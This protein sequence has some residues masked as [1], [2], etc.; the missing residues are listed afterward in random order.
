MTIT[1]DRCGQVFP[2]PAEVVSV[3]TAT[4]MVVVRMDRTELNGHRET[5][6]PAVAAVE[7][8]R[9][10]PVLTVPKAELAGR[11]G[12][13]L[14]NRA[15]VAVGGSRACTMCGVTGTD[16]MTALANSIP[17]CGACGEGNTHPAPGESKGLCAEWNA[18]R[19]AQS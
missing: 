7:V 1:C 14:D 18:A 8:R 2:V 17:C 5:C 13:M 19:E 4:N 9:A 3:D 11:I 6:K 15:Y 12:L 10:N 16:C